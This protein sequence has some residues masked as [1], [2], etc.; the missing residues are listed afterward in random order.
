[1]PRPLVSVPQSPMRGGINRH[2]GDA[3]TYDLVD[4]IDVIGADGL[5]RRRD[6]Y[7]SIAMAAP[8]RLPGGIAFLAGG[9]PT[10]LLG[11][12]RAL[13]GTAYSVLY[14]GC[15]EQF[16]GFFWPE[17]GT[18]LAPSDNLRLDLAYLISGPAWTTL[19]W[20]LDRTVRHVAASNRNQSLAGG[21]VSWHTG[22]FSSSWP[23][24][25]LEGLA[26][27][28]WLRL[29][30]LDSA[31]D[32][33]A[34]TPTLYEPGVEV[35]QLNSVNGIFPSNIKSSRF[36]VFGS[37]RRTRRGQEEGAQ[38]GF[39]DNPVAGTKTGYVVLDEGAGILGD[40][41]AW[42]TWTGT[43]SRGT[44]NKLTKDG[45]AATGTYDWDYN[46]WKGGRVIQSAA[47]TAVTDRDITVAGATAAR[48]NEYEHC[49]L[50]IV[51]KGA[52]GASVGEERAIVS[53]A[54]NGK[55][56]HEDDFGTTPDTDN[57]VDIYKPPAR[58][59]VDPGTLSPL[60]YEIKSNDASTLTLATGVNF[61]PEPP[62]A[63]EGMEVKWTIGRSLR[64][65]AR[66]GLR[67]SAV[68]D[69][70]TRCLVL[71]NGEVALFH[72]GKRLRPWEADWE[73]ISAREY[74]GAV[75]DASAETQRATVVSF[76]DREPPVGRFVVLFQ[77]RFIVAGIKGSPQ[78]VRYS[79]PSLNN[80]IWPLLYESL[81]F[82]QDQGEITGLA[83]I[84][85]RL[86]A[87]TPTAIFEAQGPNDDGQ[88]AFRQTSTGVGFVSHHAVASIAV[89]GSSALIGPSSDG[90]WVYNGA[91]PIEVLPDWAQVLEGGVNEAQIHKAVGVALPHEMTYYLAVAPRGET[92]NTRILVYNYKDKTWWVWSAPWGVSS[93]AVDTDKRGVQRL[94]IGTDDGHIQTL[95]NAQTDDGAS[96][97]AR[98]RGAWSQPFG[99][100]E[101]AVVGLLATVGGLADGSMRLDLHTQRRGRAAQEATVY[102]DEGWSRWGTDEWGTGVWAESGQKTIRVNVTSGTKATQ[103]ALEVGGS[104][105]WSYSGGELLVRPMSRRGRR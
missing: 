27:K 62:D 31:G 81:V 85:D 2:I 67:W 102:P 56:T 38:I 3:R 96:I 19:P 97:S 17:I 58:L 66:P 63:T 90:V 74:V 64:W 70:I 60:N 72:D 104:S 88:F 20:W 68:L 45:V 9:T 22:D 92:K 77:Q 80:N 41:D 100:R 105:R 6:A 32:P 59:F 49:R 1:M 51:A 65:Y 14:L 35:F 12:D 78:T 15:E 54:L 29:R 10:A 44:E 103:V 71:M 25:P 69:P 53:S 34:W 94:L 75:A 50:R 82:S 93:M 76:L 61:A 39:L 42:P 86:V 4:G 84:Q 21:H 43:A 95:S 87:F 18:A 30:L 36:W 98:A 89:G 57:E 73:S 91:E 24:R 7:S 11:D 16:D 79:A 5:L 52:G 99:G 48:L 13:S 33:V 101:G 8:H 46:Q 40:N 47:V 26:Y 37:D 83:T 55:V 23:L 28:Y